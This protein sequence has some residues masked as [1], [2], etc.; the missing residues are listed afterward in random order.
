MKRIFIINVGVNAS[1]GKLQSPIFDDDTFEF[2]PIPEKTK[3]KHYH[4][5]VS[6]PLLPRYKDLLS[7]TGNSLLTYIPKSC[8]NWRVH[9][10]PEFNTFTY[11][12]YPTLSPRAANLK[13]IG[14]KDYLFFLA[15]LT[16]WKNG[17]FTKEAGFYLIGFFEIEDMLKEVTK[18]P[19]NATLKKFNNNPHV[20]RGLSNPKFW[21]RFW[22]FKGSHNSTRFKYA[23]PFDK[24]FAD[25]VMKDSKGRKWIWKNN[26]TELQTI[27]SYTRS[28]RVIEREEEVTDFLRFVDR[29]L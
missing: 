18:R 7:F 22:V 2:V 20:R 21:D 4:N 16:R 10:D 23:I 9:N 1:H 5:Y 25:K 12:D 3:S 28:C 19:S 29:F 17:S 6:C 13:K 24:N 15:R 11:G 8:W 26:K 14:I 27:G